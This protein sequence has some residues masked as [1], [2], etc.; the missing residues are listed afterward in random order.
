MFE[1]ARNGISLFE[2][3]PESAKTEKRDF[4]FAVFKQNFGFQN[5]SSIFAVYIEYGFFFSEFDEMVSD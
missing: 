1:W 3:L 2:T 4:F 5:K